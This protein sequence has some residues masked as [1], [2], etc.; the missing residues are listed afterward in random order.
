MDFLPKV[1]G[2]LFLRP[3]QSTEAL[4]G[5]TFVTPNADRIAGGVLVTLTGQNFS[6]ELDGV[7]PPV[8]RVGG[9]LATNVVVV[10][11]QTVTF[12]AP[13]SAASGVVDVSLT[14]QGHAATLADGFTYFT[15]IVTA[16]SPAF[17]PLS[18]ATQVLVAGFNFVAG[19]TV[20]FGGSAAAGVTF[21]D[22]E[23]ILV[24]TPNHAIGFVDVVVTEPSLTTATLRNGFQYT[25]L[26]RGSDIRRTPGITVRD[27]LNNAP[28]SCTLVVDG[29]S[30]E[31]VYGEKIEIIDS[32]DANRRLFSGAVQTVDQRFEELTNQLVWDVTCTDWTSMLNRRRPFGAYVSVSASLIAKDLITK[33][34]PG[35]SSA[36]VQ[37][38]LAKITIYF[39]G[40]ED[41]GTCLSRICAAI[42]GGHWYMDYSADLHLFH[43]PP[44][45]SV[46][47]P[48]APT[49]LYDVAHMTVAEGA[50]IQST[51]SF[52][53]GYYCFRHTFVYSDGSESK[54]QAI[55]NCVKLDGKHVLSFSGLPLGAAVGA[56]TCTARRIYYHSFRRL[57]QVSSPPPTKTLAQVVAE[58]QASHTAGTLYQDFGPRIGFADAA[59]LQALGSVPT[60]YAGLAAVLGYA[61]LDNLIEPKGEADLSLAPAIP[62]KVVNKFV[63]VGDN[64]TAA[65]STY[66]GT[67]GVSDPIVI[68]VPNSVSPPAYLGNSHPAGPAAPM[69]AAMR[70]A[71]GA[72]FWNGNIV[73]FKCAFLYRDGSFS[74]VGPPSNSALQRMINGQGV[75][76]YGL[77]NVPVGPDVNGVDVVARVIYM[78][79]GTFH[80][81]SPQGRSW[82]SG[83]PPSGYEDPADVWDEPTWAS[84]YD[85]NVVVP[86]NTTTAPAPFSLS[87][88]GTS[89]T[90]SQLAAGLDPGAAVGSGN[91]IFGN[92]VT[93]S[94]DPLPLWPN[95]DGPSLEL[96]NPPTDVDGSNTYLLLDPPVKRS[97]DGS[98]VRNRVTVTGSGSF[99]RE[100][101]PAGEFLI[102]V[103]DITAFSPTGGSV[104]VEGRLVTFNSLAGVPGSASLVLDEALAV[105]IAEGVP[106]N[107]FFQAD[108][109]QSQA[110]LGKAELDING[111]PT[112]GVHEYGIVDTSLKARFQLYMRAMAELELFAFPIVTVT[113]STRDPNSRS[114]ATV[115]FNLTSPPI[116]GDF[117]IQDVTIDQIHD[118]SDALMP[119]YNVTAS[120]VRYELTDLLLQLMQSASVSGGGNGSF[121]GVQAS[122]TATLGSN[123]MEPD[124]S[125]TVFEGFI[126]GVN[127]T[128]YNN[129][130][131]G[132]SSIAAPSGVQDTRGYW[133]RNTSGS[134]I[135]NAA[136]WVSITQINMIY[137]NPRTVMH[138][139]TDALNSIIWFMGYWQNNL[140][141][142]ETPSEQGVGLRYLSS[143]GIL[144]IISFGGSVPVLALGPSLGS[145]SPNTEYI[146]VLE[147]T[148]LAT[149]FTAHLYNLTTGLH[150]SG[151]IVVPP[152]V[153][154]FA[155]G[156]LLV[157][158]NRMITQ[159]AAACSLQLKRV[160]IEMDYPSVLPTLI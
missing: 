57:G 143:N 159:K 43:T 89:Y 142:F 153:N 26:T 44:P 8:V 126:S 66:F 17:G 69:V 27:V 41:F 6:N 19:S 81:G 144:Q 104:K 97:I 16:V 139:R 158:Q 79:N 88:L 82:G 2:T 77:A 150:T 37:T 91:Q 107:N 131:W 74:N 119:R 128:L 22:T 52:T 95:D 55:S 14:Q 18:G 146:V 59:A 92:N 114:G 62:F 122:T 85:S 120:S 84:V 71:R 73:Q 141:N 68:D 38:N 78:S 1:P 10:N 70:T 28:N 23:H 102:P 130:A 30:N 115:R 134:V 46:L 72:G 11:A 36:H 51:F 67:V 7:T 98:Q 151:A 100:A 90:A 132:F 137:A 65:F 154:T 110:L 111:N 138:I 24:T 105:A 35:F 124:R 133:A 47:P 121:A 96:D 106:I 64:A 58:L 116:V 93:L 123:G 145:L 83:G 63:Q 94:V 60:T 53:P 3:T 103:V 125:R 5:L 49:T 45:A 147:V 33:Y 113:Y 42:G 148:A 9:A 108:N 32:F 21:I 4:P 54:L 76:G 56:L 31:P 80:S 29:R 136:G 75:G 156:Q 12:N 61:D 140:A 157:H 149:L 40:S 129:P 20:T 25:L 13:A 112:D 160:F 109:V 127:G 15:S 117:L 48:V 87:S 39:D 50:L 86:D 135:G 34:A 118:E 155:S 99:V 152:T 101:V